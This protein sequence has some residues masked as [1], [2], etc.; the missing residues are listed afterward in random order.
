MRGSLN[1][2]EVVHPFC[3]IVFVVLGVCCARGAGRGWG[4]KDNQLQWFGCVQRE[5]FRF[6]NFV[7]RDYMTTPRWR[8]WRAPNRCTWA[9]GAL[10][11]III[12]LGVLCIAGAMRG[13]WKGCSLWTCAQRAV[14]SSLF[15]GLSVYDASCLMFVTRPIRQPSPKCFVLGNAFNG[16]HYVR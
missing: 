2:C 6:K 13:Q 10:M 16:T 5:N 8:T 12:A 14:T 1:S 7:L 3:F 11:G 9:K 15:D 4:E